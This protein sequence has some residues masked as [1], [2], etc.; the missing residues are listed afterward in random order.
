MAL[1]SGFFNSMN[2]DRR[3]DSVDISL[4]FDGLISDGV[5]AT[6]GNGFIVSALSGMNITVGTGRAWFN[7]TWS[8]NDS[9][10]ILA[11]EQAELIL[12]RIDTVV[13][14][15]NVT[16][17]VRMNTIKIL[18]GTPSSTPVPPTLTNAAGVYQ[19]PYADIYVASNV[20][21]ISNGNIT[22][23]IGTTAC[24][25][26]TGIIETLDASLLFQTW[27]ANYDAFELANQGTFDAWIAAAQ[28]TFDT[29]LALVQ[30]QLDE[31][32]EAQLLALI[33]AATAEVQAVRDDVDN[34]LNDM[35]EMQT[36]FATVA[37]PLTANTRLTVND[38]YLNPP[39]QVSPGAFNTIYLKHYRGNSF[40]SW[41]GTELVMRQFVPTSIDL[42]DRIVSTTEIPMDIYLSW[43]ND[44][45][46]C[47]YGPN[48]SNIYTRGAAADV[49]A[50]KGILLN[51][52]EIT[53]TNGP[54]SV[55]VPAK[56]AT[57]IGQIALKGYLVSSEL[58]GRVFWDQR[59][60]TLSNFFNQMR[61]TVYKT[62]ATSHTYTSTTARPWNNYSSRELIVVGTYYDSEKFAR[63]D[64]ESVAKVS[65][66][67]VIATVM[68]YKNSSRINNRKIDTKST[69]SQ[70]GTVSGEVVLGTGINKFEAYEKSSAATSTFE[71]LYLGL[72]LYA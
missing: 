26:V 54:N 69:V 5:Y 7:H 56:Y 51:N 19:Y 70:Q 71:E 38:L 59:N 24:P 14:E 32:T 62:E 53:I 40:P 55:V 3:Y 12:D 28:S 34:V 37:I 29:W 36:A 39:E 50:E 10:M 2:G 57:V 58:R 61:T 6:F 44:Q 65:A 9:V 22:N 20:T 17:S 1:R 63:Y 11:V 43:Y 18:K 8:Y 49:I 66:A 31:V 67:T 45:L 25:F 72:S 27:D 35:A 47:G 13:L 64:L 15:V 48:W 46:F 41:N 42:N 52:A 16:D 68:P 23:R 33:N 21:S 4:L 30:G 60:R